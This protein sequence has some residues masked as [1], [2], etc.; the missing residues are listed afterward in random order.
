MIG[1]LTSSSVTIDHT[2]GCG[3]VLHT[4]TTAD[5]SDDA[6]SSAEHGHH[7]NVH[8]QRHRDLDRE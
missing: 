1:F 6:R 4:L 2:H 7:R 5:F 8:L 3:S